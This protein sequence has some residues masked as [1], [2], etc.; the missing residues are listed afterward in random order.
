M[1]IRRSI[2]SKEPVRHRLYVSRFIQPTV[3]YFLKEDKIQ[4]YLLQ[5]RQQNWKFV[6][7]WQ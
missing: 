1:L 2:T 5:Q 3:R 4:F 7:V 6:I